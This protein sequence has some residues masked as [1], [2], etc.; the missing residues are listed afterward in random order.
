LLILN[1]WT[2]VF[3]NGSHFVRLTKVINNNKYRKQGSLIDLREMVQRLA[4]G[5]GR[6]QVS[7]PNL[8]QATAPAPATCR[9]SLRQLAAGESHRR[10]PAAGTHQSPVTVGVSCRKP[11]TRSIAKTFRALLSLVVF[12]MDK[13]FFYTK[14]KHCPPL[15]LL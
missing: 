13:V 12:D 1:V 4:T 11:N 2:N 10:S 9:H 3:I 15:S 5:R 6:S 14:T 8:Q 7:M